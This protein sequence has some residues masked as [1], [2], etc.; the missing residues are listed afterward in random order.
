PPA[1]LAITKS[2]PGEAT[3]G[4]D[5]NYH[6]T[7]TNSGLTPS[8][9]GTVTDVLPAQVSFKSASAGCTFTAPSTVSCS[10]GPL[11][12]NLSVSFDIAVHISDAAIVT[13]TNTA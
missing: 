10:F 6:L 12:P 4:T 5:I 8:T 1:D 2:A 11:A 3:S 13:L 9:G 7:V